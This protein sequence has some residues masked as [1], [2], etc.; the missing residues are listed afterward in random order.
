M[1]WNHKTDIN[2]HKVQSELSETLGVKTGVRHGD[3]LSPLHFKGVLEK[4]IQEW[5]KQK[6]ILKINHIN[7]S[8]QRKIRDRSPG[9]CRRPN[10]LNLRCPNRQKTDGATKRNCGERW[11]AGIIEKRNTLPAINKHQNTWTDN[12]KKSNECHNFNTPVK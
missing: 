5:H 10:H 12:M 3:G 11:P 1:K 7:H 9:I 8:R 6:L 4:V 2:R